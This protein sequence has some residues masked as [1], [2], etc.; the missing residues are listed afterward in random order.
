M[1]LDL[2]PNEIQ[3]LLLLA[4]K[5]HAALVEKVLSQA[6]ANANQGNGA[7]PPASPEPPKS[8]TQ[9]VRGN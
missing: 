6:N 9:A 3:T 2:E 1:N 7:E 5:G 8:D 4:G